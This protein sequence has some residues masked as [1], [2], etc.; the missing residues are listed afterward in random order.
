VPRCSGT[1]GAGSPTA[2]DPAWLRFAAIAERFV[3]EHVFAA[4]RECVFEAWV[5]P[6]VLRRW[7]GAGPDWTSPAVEIDL[8]PGGRSRLS[9]QDPSGTVRTVGGRYVEVDPPCGLVYTWAWEQPHAVEGEDETLV[10]VDFHERAGGE[11][12]VVL[13]HSGL[14]RRRPPRRAPAGL[15]ALH[16]KPAGARPR[17]R[18][19]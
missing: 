18:L 10:T 15:G 4:S 1:S 8:R 2:A 11:T 3:I 6:E 14:R 13:T 16:R 5:S 19:T 12:R 9:V 7:W 17:P